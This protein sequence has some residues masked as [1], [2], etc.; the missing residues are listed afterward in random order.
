MLRTEI[1]LQSYL[2]ISY[3]ILSVHIFGSHWRCSTISEKFLL[4][5]I[6]VE[7]IFSI[8]IAKLC[9][10]LGFLFCSLKVNS[11]VNLISSSQ[12]KKLNEFSISMLHHGS[13][14][15]IA[16]KSLSQLFGRGSK[17]IG[18]LGGTY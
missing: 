9:S 13:S 12:C 7:L 16:I 17:K 15:R 14:C 11:Q 5:F 10:T 8:Y 3:F 2:V 1:C 4:K 6:D 18:G